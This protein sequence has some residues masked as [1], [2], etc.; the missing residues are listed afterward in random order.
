M[1]DDDDDRRLYESL[2]RDYAA[3]KPKRVDLQKLF[4][5][6]DEKMAGDE[7]VTANNYRAMLRKYWCVPDM[8]EADIDTFVS[9]TNKGTDGPLGR[10]G[11]NSIYAHSP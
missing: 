5:E 2:L 8:P 4:K 10:L 3:F 6:M 11:Y 1:G 9:L 7:G